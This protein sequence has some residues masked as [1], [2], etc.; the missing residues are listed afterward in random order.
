MCSY[1]VIAVVCLKHIPQIQTQQDRITCNPSEVQNISN[2][3]PHTL[4]LFYILLLFALAY[5]VLKQLKSRL[6][7]FKNDVTQ[8]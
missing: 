5:S 1:E 3:L 8:I 6:E 4:L 2:P 7:R